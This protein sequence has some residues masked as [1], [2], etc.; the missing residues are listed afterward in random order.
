MPRQIERVAWFVDGFNLYYSLKE[1]KN[2][3]YL[4]LDL[5]KLADNF[6]R[7]YQSNLVMRYYT[8]SAQMRAESALRQSFYLEALIA[9]PTFPIHLQVNNFSTSYWYCKD[10]DGKNKSYSEKQTDVALGVSMLKGAL[11]DEYDT[12]FL[13]SADTDFIPAILEVKRAGKKVVLGLPPGRRS[14][15]LEITVDGVI[16]VS[17][18]DLRK[19]Q[20]SETINLKNGQE[21]EKPDFYRP[22]QSPRFRKWPLVHKGSD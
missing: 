20:L 3:K 10:C 1:L 22:G 14:K 16:S 17:E 2:G 15:D 9:N 6:I 13:I 12:A 19:A 5:T 18:N 7:P 11:L 8:A 4:W 21:I